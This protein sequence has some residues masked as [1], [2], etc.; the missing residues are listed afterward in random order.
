MPPLGPPPARYAGKPHVRPLSASTVVARIHSTRFGP[1]QFN[2]RYFSADREGLG[3]RF[4][5]TS[6]DPYS[7]LY[8]AEDAGTAVSE[9]LLRYLE[10]DDSGTRMLPRSLVADKMISWIETQH[11]LELVDLSTGG[12][13]GAIGADHRL[14]TATER[15]Y[16]MTRRWSAWIRRQTKHVPHIA[17]GLIWQSLREPAGYACVFFEDRCPRDAFKICTVGLPIPAA[18]R[19]LDHGAGRDFLEEILKSYNVA[20]SPSPSHATARYGLLRRL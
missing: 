16:H 14:T 1:T 20:L 8:A 13:L 5:S 12:G 19:K 2:P 15:E 4:D 11:D 3:G 10:P 6:D 18:E 9:A 7:F 17:Q